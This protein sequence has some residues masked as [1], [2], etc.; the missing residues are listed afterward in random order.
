SFSKLLKK[1][2]N[3]L[4]VMFYAPWCGYCKRL[5]PEF[6]AAA[7][8]VKNDATLVGIDVDKPHMMHLRLQY[9][10]TG[11]PT[12][13][14]FENGHLK[15]KYGGE[16][17]KAGI[18]SWLQNPQESKEKET[19][20]E[21]ADENS[22]VFHLTDLTFNEFIKQNPSVLVMFYAPWCGHC[23]QMKPGYTEAAQFLK[24]EE[25]P[26]VLAAVDATKEKKIALEN[27][28]KGFPTIRYFRNGEFAFEVNE[29]DK[30]KIIEFMKDPKEPP[31]PPPQEMKW[32]E[33]ES[34]IVH[35][36]DDTFKQFLKKKKHCLVMFYA[37][38]CGHCKKSKPEYMAAATVYKE[39]PKVAFA[40]VDCT[41]HT[42]T[43]NSHDVKGYPTF[44]YFNYGK[45]AQKYMGGREKNDF[46]TFMKDPQNAAAS[47]SNSL[48]LE[49]LENQW[50]F[51]NGYQSLQFLT[52]TNFDS[53]IAE[54]V[55]TLV[56]FYAPWCGHCK[57][58]KPDFAEAAEIVKKEGLGTLGVVD[59]TIEKELADKFN[60][61]GF[62][63][64]KLFTDGHEIEYSSGRA[65]E[66]LVQYMIQS[67]YGEEAAEPLISKKNSSKNEGKH[68]LP[69][70]YVHK[71]TTEIYK[72]FIKEKAA[73]FVMF[74]K[75]D[76]VLCQTVKPHFLKAAKTP[77]AH[78]NYFAAVDCTQEE[79]L[80][81]MENILTYPSF[82][83]YFD[84]TLHKKF[85]GAHHYA[86]MVNFINFEQKSTSKGT[87]EN[88]RKDR[89]DL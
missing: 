58:M 88:I 75:P 39:D 59:A 7:S 86:T 42:G 70:H 21:W 18:I 85:N 83:L 36:T 47:S 1:D 63:T 16:N 82:Y 43:C 46:I 24:D 30:D 26:G 40:A 65:K 87:L 89:E 8:E 77:Y 48:P 69:S 29:R 81:A 55:Q 64:L 13:Y 2:R 56:L 32:E 62:P 78:N 80:C 67:L 60:I 10:I 50:K 45:N 71:L 61:K 53:V 37:P 4:L 31:P 54:N 17:N 14:Y 25:I 34:D 19:E 9:N 22:N 3:P 20:V 12:L 33:I 66:D 73:V 52:S 74:Y 57:Q 79:A 84:G 28:I 27:N 23:K 76:L 68:F 6:A 5:K 49:T 41:V 72:Q 51:L 38:W 11:F 15:F 44:K 35:L